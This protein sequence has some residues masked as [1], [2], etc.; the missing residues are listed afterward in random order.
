MKLLPATQW[1]DRPEIWHAVGASAEELV[2]KL[3]IGAIKLS[4]AQLETRSKSQRVQGSAGISCPAK[5]RRHRIVELDMTE[6]AARYRS[7][8]GT[9]LFISFPSPLLMIDGRGSGAQYSSH[10][11]DRSDQA[12]IQLEFDW[13]ELQDCQD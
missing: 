1:L 6:L 12:P 5:K 2:S 7:N 10:R 13:L 3:R 8:C 11:D 4:H 9:V